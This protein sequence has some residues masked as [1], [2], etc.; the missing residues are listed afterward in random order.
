MTVSE[1]EQRILE[2]MSTAV[3]VFDGEAC[4]RYLNPAGEML[5]ALSVRKALGAH[6]GDL[7]DS[8]SS[9]WTAR[10]LPWTAWSLRRWSRAGLRRCWWR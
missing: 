1:R 4:L 6:V 5:L 9:G 8:S 3:L 2:G 10:S 7:L